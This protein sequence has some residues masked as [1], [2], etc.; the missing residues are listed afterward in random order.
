MSFPSSTPRTPERVIAADKHDAAKSG[1][2][3]ERI[4]E[5]IAR[6]LIVM[7]ASL[8]TVAPLARLPVVALL[9]TQLLRGSLAHAGCGSPTTKMTHLYTWKAEKL[10]VSV[11]FRKDPL[12]GDLVTY[13]FIDA[14]GQP[15]DTVIAQLKASAPQV[16][17]GGQESFPDEPGKG[18]KPSATSRVFFALRKVS[19]RRYRRAPALLAKRFKWKRLRWRPC[20]LK[21]RRGKRR[22]DLL[23]P[24]KPPITIALPSR[25]KPRANTRGASNRL[26]YRLAR[27][28]E[29]DLVRLRELPAD[30]CTS[31][32][33]RVVNWRWL[34]KNPTRFAPLF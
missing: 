16:F 27:C 33:D 11:F 6:K 4:A 2:K 23:I 14:K 29:K 26:E 1:Q 12:E 30:G 21:K 22:W 13:R 32:R 18:K 19:S 31:Y 15:L 28:Y 3:K 25:E 8:K 5:P 10:I 17:E 7:K 20:R 24:Q 34:R 9:A